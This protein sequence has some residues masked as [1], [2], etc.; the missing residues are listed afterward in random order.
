MASKILA[1]LLLFL[2]FELLHHSNAQSWI[3]SGFWRTNSV[4][5]ASEVNS[6]LFTHLICAF[7]DVDNST[8]QLSIPSS[9]VSIFSN[10]T[11][12]VKRKNPSIVTL[13]S[14]WA[15]QAQT[16]Q[17]T[18]GQIPNSTVLSSMASQPSHRKSFIESSIKTAKLF[19]FHGLDLSW[20]WPSTASD[21]INLGTLLEE[22]RAAINSESRNSNK[23]RLILTMK[24]PYVPTLHSVSYPVDS[25]RRNLDWANVV[26]Y[27]YYVSTR[28]NFTGAHAAL[29]D[30]SSNISTD[31]GIREWTRK[32]LPASKLVLGLPYHGHAWRLVNP[33]ENGVGAPA[34]RSGLTSDGS[35]SYWY[36][37]FYIR[38]FSNGAAK[39][40]NATYV[41][42]Y[43]TFGAN[44]IGYDDV[45]TIKA[46]VSYAKEKKLLGYFVSQVSNDENGVLSLAAAQ[47]D[48]EDNQN[49]R[50][51][52]IILLPIAMVIFILGFMLC[53]LRRW[54]LKSKGNESLSNSDAPNLQVFRFADIVV[55]TNNFSIENKLGEGGCGPVY[56]AYDLW[57]DGKGMEFMDPSLDD[58]FS[59][60]KLM[61]CMQVA[62]LCVQEKPA[63]RPSM[64]EVSSMLKNETA[65]MVMPKRP[66][67]SIK[68]DE[69]ERNNSGLQQVICSNEA[70]VSQI[71]PQ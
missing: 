48:V 19:G 39:L 3:Q 30:P 49:K 62:L 25:I 31:F 56:K 70:T 18:F 5:A 2:P 37:K 54:V 38:R 53:Y 51:L 10:F 59:S 40:Y 11:D 33:D 29:Y 46:K 21:L 50:L 13:L 63:D 64:L 35:M 24:V 71:L 41:V 20:V 32:G 15:G 66:G 69:D 57:K 22:W 1:F 6:A 65:A 28:V 44:W 9:D 8:Y 14:I 45:E 34:S 27:D 67:F 68:T 47:K 23:T 4:I 58:E 55:A 42:N 12:S 36:I 52:M 61:T 60:C 7:A 43:Y 26:A 17:S 16:Y